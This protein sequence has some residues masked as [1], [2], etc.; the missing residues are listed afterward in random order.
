M[1]PVYN[2][3]L[4][5]LQWISFSMQKKKDFPAKLVPFLCKN[6]LD[7]TFPDITI[8]PLYWIKFSAR[9]A[10]STDMFGNVPTSQPSLLCTKGKRQDMLFHA[11]HVIISTNQ[12]GSWT[13]TH[14]QWSQPDSCNPEASYSIEDKNFGTCT[15]D[16]KGAVSDHFFNFYILLPL[17]RK[18][19][20]FSS[21]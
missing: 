20:K 21:K 7:I 2:K 12:T 4:T 16:V 3:L 6:F 13:L 1:L 14:K 19:S 17:S 11:Q 15:A 18:S 9:G 5:A 10:S 8:P